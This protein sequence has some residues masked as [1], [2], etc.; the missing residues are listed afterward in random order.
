M[1][2][3]GRIRGGGAYQSCSTLRH[4]EVTEGGGITRGIRSIG[5]GVGIRTSPF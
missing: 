4:D 2:Y 1:R 3:S 5:I